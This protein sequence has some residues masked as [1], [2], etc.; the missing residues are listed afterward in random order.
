[1]VSYNIV[2]NSLNRVVGSAINDAYYN[3]DFSVLPATG[4]YKITFNYMGSLNSI[5]AYRLASLH[6]DLGQINNYTTTPLYTTANSIRCLGLLS[7]SGLGLIA[8]SNF[9]SAT[10]I[11]NRPLSNYFNVQVLDNLGVPFLDDSG[12]MLKDYILIINLE[13]VPP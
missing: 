11:Q 6:V 9:N 13:L 3:F 4:S 7:Y 1:M 12:A 2:L 8:T 10:Y 5:N